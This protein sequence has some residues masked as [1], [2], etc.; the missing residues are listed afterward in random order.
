MALSYPEGLNKE[1]R[2]AFAELLDHIKY[3]GSPGDPLY[4][5]IQ[6]F[7]RAKIEHFVAAGGDEEEYK[8]NALRT[9]LVAR[10]I[11][12]SNSLLY[13]PDPNG[14]RKVERVRQEL[15]HYQRKYLTFL[16]QDNPDQR[17]LSMSG[18][19]PNTSRFWA[20]S[21]SSTTSRAPLVSSGGI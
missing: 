1:R 10:L 8:W 17:P 7:H 11:V 13:A 18:I 4:L 2:E 6:K 14:T 3:A 5:R 19:C 9:K 21:P 12:P 16:D 15:V 20:A